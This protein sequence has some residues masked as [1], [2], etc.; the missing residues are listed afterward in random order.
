[1]IDVVTL[2]LAKKQATAAA[3]SA[4][5][6]EEAKTAATSAA[7]TAEKAAASVTAATAEETKQY[8]GL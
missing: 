7:E 5:K 1:M 6:A 3:E 4:R 8:L 2:T